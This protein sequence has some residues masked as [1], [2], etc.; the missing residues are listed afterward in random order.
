MKTQ[1]IWFG[2]ASGLA[3]SML[4]GWSYGFFAIMLP[5]FIL[6]RTDSFQLSRL[7]MVV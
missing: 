4:F 1:R 5:L 6:S 3:L 2:C 7:L